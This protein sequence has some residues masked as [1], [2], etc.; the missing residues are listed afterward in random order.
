[1]VEYVIPLLLGMAK[2]MFILDL[3][4]R[5]NFG[6]SIANRPPY[7]TLA[8]VAC[9]SPKRAAMTRLAQAGMHENIS[10]SK[11]HVWVRKEG[12]DESWGDRKVD[13]RRASATK[14]GCRVEPSASSSFPCHSR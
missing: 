11:T 10:T 6:S 14:R 3:E 1:M 4:S 7:E 8:A 2:V 5:N 13:L 9:R 12:G